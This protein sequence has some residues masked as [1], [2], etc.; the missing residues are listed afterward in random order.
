MTLELI[1]IHEDGTIDGILPTADPSLEY[2]L[3]E[4]VAN[5]KRVG[6]QN[7]WNAYVTVNDGTVVGTCAFKAPPKQG[8]VEI[9]YFTF[10]QY[11][12]HGYA[13]QMAACLVQIAQDTDDSIQVIARTM[14]I[15]GPSASVL[16]KCGF[17]KTAEILDPED[18]LVWEWEYRKN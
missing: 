10:P 14:P 5:Y 17:K 7:P 11:E 16:K 1:P 4:C 13:T 18:G 9:A 12:N 3:P 2:V 15:A 8:R 6:F